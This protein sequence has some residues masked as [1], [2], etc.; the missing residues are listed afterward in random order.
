[1]LTVPAF[2][3]ASDIRNDASPDAFVIELAA[4]SQL[5][6]KVTT[7][8]PIGTPLRRRVARN[9]AEPPYGALAAGTSMVGSALTV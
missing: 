6:K 5:A 4:T 2:R 1:M 3:P 8:P 7:P 9:S